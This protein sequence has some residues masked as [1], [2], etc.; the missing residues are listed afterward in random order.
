MTGAT[1]ESGG[2]DCREAAPPGPLAASAVFDKRRG[3]K[4][5]R[6]DR[7]LLT[8][9]AGLERFTTDDV[10]SRAGNTYW[11]G[12]ASVL[13]RSLRQEGHV[14]VVSDPGSKPYVYEWVAE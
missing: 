6:R 10:V 11:Y 5:R 9:A 13:L 4:A 12:A 14:R 1:I 2:V 3:E 7:A 8:A